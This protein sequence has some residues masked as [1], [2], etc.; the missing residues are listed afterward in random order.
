MV[1]PLPLTPALSL[2]STAL[3]DFQVNWQTCS[4]HRQAYIYY[5]KI[6]KKRVCQRMQM[7]YVWQ[8]ALCLTNVAC[9]AVY[10]V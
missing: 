6:M 10:T 1:A 5:S 8:F 4:S 7:W 9:D 2:H 3:L